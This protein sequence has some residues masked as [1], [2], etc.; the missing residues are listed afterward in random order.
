VITVF[1]IAFSS[2]FPAFTYWF[3]RTRRD[4]L[5]TS[6][7]AVSFNSL[8]LTL[9]T[10]LSVS[11][12]WYT[13]LFLVR[14][15]VLASSVVFL[16][17][18]QSAQLILTIITGFILIRYIC[19]VKPMNSPILNYLEVFNEVTLLTTTVF[20]TAFT[21]YTPNPQPE[22]SVEK[23]TREKMGWLIIAVTSLY[24]AINLLFIVQGILKGIWVQL[25][26]KC[27]RSEEAVKKEP[28]SKYLELPRQVNGV[29]IDNSISANN[30]SN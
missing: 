4:K 21:D 27:K 9:E 12:V 20:L 22:K 11:S 6:E 26:K 10:E 17:R 1:L 24:I 18:S 7:Y 19:K 15:L 13:T 23:E 30:I 14:R 25:S 16:G 2:G 28:A 8:Y 3:L 29:R 5:Q